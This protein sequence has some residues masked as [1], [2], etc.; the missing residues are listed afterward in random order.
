MVTLCVILTKIL[1]MLMLKKY[2]S[3]SISDNSFSP[4][5]YLCLPPEGCSGFLS[6]EYIQKQVGLNKLP[7]ICCKFIKKEVKPVLPL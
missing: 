2:Y 1:R 4:K 3:K 7:D 5:S 6:S